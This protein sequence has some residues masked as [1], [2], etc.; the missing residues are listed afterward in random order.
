MKKLSFVLA[1][2]MMTLSACKETDQ[3]RVA[4]AQNCLDGAT[5]ATAAQCVSMVDGI[6]TK[7][8]Y[9]IRCSG[10]FI[11]EGF[12]DANRLSSAMDAIENNGGSSNSQTM[13]SVLSFRNFGSPAANDQAA[14]NAVN[15]CNKAGSKGLVMLASVTSIATTAA[16]L[17][18]TTTPSQGDINQGLNDIVA[19]GPSSSQAQAVGSAAIAAYNANCAGDGGSFGQFCDQFESAMDGLSNPGDIGVKLAQCYLTPAAPGCQG[20]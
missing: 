6:N 17:A 14:Q 1:A 13:M 11:Q 3:D 18:G 2:M 7:G 20:F 9:L 15:Y 4:D 8:A 19:A 10:L 5:S 12:M 16:A